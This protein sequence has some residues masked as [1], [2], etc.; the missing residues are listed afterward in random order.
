MVDSS[1]PLRNPGK[2]SIH[3]DWVLRCLSSLTTARADSQLLGPRS[4]MLHC[5]VYAFRF[6]T[7]PEAGVPAR[8]RARLR[9][10]S[11]VSIRITSRITLRTCGDRHTP[12]P[13]RHRILVRDHGRTLVLLI[14]PTTY[15]TRIMHR[16]FGAVAY[17]PTLSNVPMPG[18][19]IAAGEHCA[20][21]P[22]GP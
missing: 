15:R 4:V 17:Q 19:I 9:C 13:V 18:R 14:R 21:W 22:P 5:R 11:S 1:P 6:V 10:H 7:R 2:A 16:R 20:M 3:P 12:F 8:I